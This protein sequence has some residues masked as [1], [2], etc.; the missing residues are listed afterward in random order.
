MENLPELTTPLHV[1]V[2]FFLSSLFS[3]V[4]LQQC[5]WKEWNYHLGGVLRFCKQSDSTYLIERVKTEKLQMVLVD[6]CIPKDT[7]KMIAKVSMFKD[8][9]PK[10]SEAIF[11]AIAA[12]VDEVVEKKG[13]DLVLNKSSFC[14]GIR[15]NQYFLSILGVSC[16]EIDEIVNISNMHGYRAKLSGGGGGGCVICFPTEL[17]H[18]GAVMDFIKELNQK[19]YDAQQVEI[20]GDG[21]IVEDGVM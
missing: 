7:G 17:A 5:I 16:E 9:L 20:G 8:R 6:T 4:N 2:S 18:K 12:I 21:L 15:L 10:V 1:M 14:E 13:E 19:G 3:F 11:N